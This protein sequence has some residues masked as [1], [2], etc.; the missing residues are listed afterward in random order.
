MEYLLLARHS[1]RGNRVDPPGHLQQ[2][3]PVRVSIVTPSFRGAQWLP[4]C[5]ASVADQEGVAVEHI[6][7]D[8]CSDDGTQ[9]ILAREPRVRAFIEK[10]RG[11]YD[12]VNRGLTRATGDVLAYLNC[13]EQF[14]PG[15]LKA[16]S[17]HFEANPHLDAIVSDT[18]V[19]D[20]RGDYIC[21]RCALAPGKHQM[22]VRFPVLT[23]ALFI[24]SKVFQG[25]GIRCDTAWRALGDW[26]WVMEMVRRGVRFGVLP[27]MTSTFADTGDNLCL[28]PVALEER[29]R[30]WAMAPG[31]VR[32]MKYPFIL[33]YRL[34]LA[35]RGAMNYKPFDYS[36]HTLESPARRVTKHAANPSSFWNRRPSV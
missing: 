14:L 26:V 13:D 2:F 28:H 25:M 1:A 18:I 5:I 8:S 32:M 34:Q 7:Q 12:A 27:V 11:M 16:V 6:V 31:W 29:A 24:R 17:D 33:K 15:A 19:T 3:A 9:E 30:K 4:L 22:W 10:D 35:A 36:L 21:H 23:C 20:T